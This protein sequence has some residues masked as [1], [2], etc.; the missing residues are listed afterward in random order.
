MIAT[1]TALRER[2]NEELTPQE[3]I[4]LPDTL[5]ISPSRLDFILNDPKEFI[6]AEISALADLLG[7]Q[8]QDLIMVYG[9]GWN[10]VTLQQAADLLNTEG[11]ALG[12]V[13]HIA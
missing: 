7:D 4:D 13:A 6:L 9:L 8:P 12:T 1:S 5:G 10:R 11:L 3:V 2:L